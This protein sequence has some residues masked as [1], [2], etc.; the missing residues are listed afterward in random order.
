[1]EKN[2]QPTLSFVLLLL[3]CIAAYPQVCLAVVTAEAAS[4]ERQAF[5]TV[6]LYQVNLLLA[7]IA[8]LGRVSLALDQC[9]GTLGE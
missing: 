4:V 9:L 8:V 2:H 3:E 7:E 5:R 6:L 1:M